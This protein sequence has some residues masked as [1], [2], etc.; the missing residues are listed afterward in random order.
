MGKYG[1]RRD[2]FIPE[3]KGLS[4][5]IVILIN[6]WCGSSTEEL[7]LAARQSS[8]V[9]LV[10]ETVWAKVPAEIKTGQTRIIPIC[11]VK[12]G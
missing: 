1:S 4:K 12:S 9:I 3:L 10:E 2:R 11:P 5:K 6:K 8:K 7:L